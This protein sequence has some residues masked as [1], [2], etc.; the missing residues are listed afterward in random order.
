KFREN[1]AN[2]EFFE[3]FGCGV[4]A[5]ELI[6]Q[7]PTAEANLHG[8]PDGSIF[9]GEGFHFFHIVDEMGEGGNCEAN[10]TL[11]Q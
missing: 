11:F 6:E 2:L 10:K 1:H 7:F 4:D 3:L 8:N 9:G 5:K